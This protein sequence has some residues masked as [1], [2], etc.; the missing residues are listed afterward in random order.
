MR[1]SRVGSRAG[2]ILAFFVGIHQAALLAVMN[3]A[4]HGR[5]SLPLLPKRLAHGSLRY[6]YL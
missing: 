3:A 4:E 5:A 2:R 1:L 6:Q